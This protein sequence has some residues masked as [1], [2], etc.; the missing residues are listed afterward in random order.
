MRTPFLVASWIPVGIGIGLVHHQNKH[1]N[2]FYAV[3]TFISVTLLH[4]GSNLA[5][6]YFDHIT[7]ND[8][9]NTSVTPF[10]GGSRVIQDGLINSKTIYT[11]AL[12]LLSAGTITGIYLAIRTQT[13]PVFVCGLTGLIIA[14]FYT[15]K[16]LQFGYHG[17][18]EL[19]AG[20]AFGPLVVIATYCIQTKYF[21]SCAVFYSIPTGLM[22]SM[23]LLINEFPDYQADK[24]A[25]KN[26]LVVLLGKKRSLFLLCF[27]LTL[28]YIYLYTAYLFKIISHGSLLAYIPIPVASYIFYKSIRTYDDPI[29][30]I[31]ACGAMIVMY[32]LTGLLLISGLI[33]FK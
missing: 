23:I 11:A 10:S 5:N 12:Y 14:Y 9:A 20:I 7:G 30:I 18:G 24:T 8:E 27:L 28:P 25:A 29:A 1:V 32:T 16:P 21:H 2:L 13:I 6:D 19:L 17:V 22:V 4:L 33:F 15:A 3:L 26:T 31:P